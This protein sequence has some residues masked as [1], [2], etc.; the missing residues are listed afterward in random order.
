MH[1]DFVD[2]NHGVDDFDLWEIRDG[3][4]KRTDHAITITTWQ[5]IQNQPATWYKPFKA[6]IGDEVHTFKAMALKRIAERCDAPYRLGYTGTLDGEETNELVLQGLFGTKHQVTTYKEL[7]EGGYIADP[8]INCL[9]MKHPPDVCKENAKASYQDESKTIMQSEARR[10]FL[11]NM[12]GKLKGNVLCLYKDIDGHLIPSHD[13]MVQ[14]FGKDRVFKIHGAVKT[15]AREVI[16]GLFDK[17]VGSILNASY[18]T[19][20]QGISII[21]IDHIVYMFP[22]KSRIRLLQSMGRG[23]RRSETKTKCDIWDI[24]DDLSHKTWKNH[25][26]RHMKVRVEEYNN[27]EF[28]YRLFMREL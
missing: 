4:E 6:L 22:T 19:C 20:Q 2:Y 18:G 21:N 3:A 10:L 9:I 15:D 24:A 12:I 16:R 23:L 13:S 27:E 28:D 26:L 1:S 11:E 14:R 8:R 5:A 17:S 7:R 25:T